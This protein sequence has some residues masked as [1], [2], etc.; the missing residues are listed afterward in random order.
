[1]R[2]LIVDDEPLARRGVSARLRTFSDVEIVGECADGAS[3]V[4][5]ILSLEP[6]LVFLDVQ[7]PE[8]DGF[9]VI[10]ALQTERLPAIIFLTAHEEHALRAFE[11]HA[12][13]Y[14]LKPL[15]DERFSVAVNRAREQLDTT[16]KADLVGR[17]LQSLDQ[18][19]GCYASRFVIRVGSRI[20][21]VSAEDLDWIAAAGD[22][23]ELHTANATHLLRETMTTLEQ[24]LDPAK[25]ARIHR[26]RIVRL[27]EI[28]ELRSIENREYIVKL[29]DGSQH[30]SSRTYADRVERWL[31]TGRIVK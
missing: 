10:R 21:I 20:Q 22:Y 25:F 5:S 28:L 24:K 11:V 4:E 2:V 27:G 7:M 1:V 29:R 31:R 18:N 12:L 3:A 8:I 26:S 14:L 16:H 17:M 15:D 13:D 19:S 6:D 30:R 9:D 23:S